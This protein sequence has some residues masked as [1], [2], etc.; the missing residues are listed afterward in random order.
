[1]NGTES[2]KGCDGKFLTS[3]LVQQMSKAK[4]YLT[5]DELLTPGHNIMKVLEMF[6]YIFK[7]Q[8]E[9]EDKQKLEQHTL[10]NGRHYSVLWAKYAMEDQRTSGCG[11]QFCV[12]LCK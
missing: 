2:F 8:W 12:H 3:Y 6:L 9:K 7:V 5:L 1:M 11:N 10:I 4:S